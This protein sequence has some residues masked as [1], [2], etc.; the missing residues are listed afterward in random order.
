[1]PKTV[2]AALKA[3]TKANAWTFEA[4]SKAKTIGAEAKASPDYITDS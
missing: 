4:N 1:M 3:K 2:N